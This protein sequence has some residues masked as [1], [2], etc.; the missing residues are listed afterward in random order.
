MAGAEGERGL[1]LDTDAVYSDA[2]ARV[3]PVYDET[4]GVDRR[5]TFQA[6]A[7][8]VGGRER[9]EYER[10]RGR[11]AGRRRDQRPHRR[12][13]R[14]LAE[15][16]GQRPASV[17]LLERRR[18]HVLRIEAFGDGVT[19]TSRRGGIGGEPR[20]RGRDR[21]RGRAHARSFYL[22]LELIQRV[23]SEIHTT[24]NT[25]ARTPIPDWPTAGPV[26]VHRLSPCHQQ[27]LR[28]VLHRP[29]PSSATSRRGAERA[30]FAA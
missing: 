1:D 28:L 18:G 2:R 21:R 30:R 9:L 26:R 24:V 13:I 12:F 6:L 27:A 5:E 14:P 19:R 8:P 4:P 25:A 15:M 11:R 7:H 22:V 17:R 3:R 20:E 23:L 29:V 10:V 16:E